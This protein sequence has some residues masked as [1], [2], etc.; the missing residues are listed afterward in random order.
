MQFH[1]FK[2]TLRTIQKGKAVK[3]KHFFSQ[4]SLLDSTFLQRL[5]KLLMAREKAPLKKKYS[6]KLLN[7]PFTVSS[8]KA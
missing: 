8:V 1:D 2:H 5:I 7:R 4:E 6:I 3:E